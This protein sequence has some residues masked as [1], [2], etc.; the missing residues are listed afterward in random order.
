MSITSLESPRH[1]RWSVYLILIVIA[2]GSMVGRI[3]A[4]KSVDML[5]VERQLRSQNRE[6]WHRTRPFLSANDRSRWLTVRALVEQNTYAIDDV[7]KDPMWDSIDIVRHKGADGKEHFYSSKP[8]LLPTI[9]AG[10]YWLINKITGATLKTHP[11]EI[12]RFMLLTINV[13]AMVLY[14]VMLA[15]LVERIGQTDW[16]RIFTVSAAAFGTL[17]TTFAIVINNHLIAAASAAVALL[18][19]YRI[20]YD[21]ERRWGYF[22]LAGF[23]GAF[24]AANEYPALALFAL[25]TLGLLIESPL[26][27][28]LAYLP[29]AA[30]VIAAALGT[31]YL[32]HGTITSP[33]GH[34]GQAD[35]D[36]NWYEF[37]YERNGKVVESYWNSPKGIDKGEPDPGKYALHALV[38][39][40]GIFSLTPLWLLSVAGIVLYGR[41]RPALTA[42]VAMTSLACLAFYLVQPITDV[43]LANYGGMTSGFRWVFWLAPLWLVAMVPVLDSL[44]AT[45]VRRSI[46]LLLLGLS[47]M[48]ASYPTWNP[49]THP[50]LTDLLMHL[51]KVTF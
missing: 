38:G 8:A 21:G 13:P 7:M 15:K 36:D 32:A 51:E 34:R 28:L 6:D 26:K 43:K 42:L 12:G 17:L 35:P 18:A 29:A 20:W 4:V 41:R 3:L 14:F 40:H 31:E 1:L 46:A 11:F 49:W 27:T 30:V 44:S 23:C 37:S 19:A 25:L 22:A 48:T 16:G 45:R 9:M 47:V 5:S 39:H 10:E 50:W 33:Y 2:A 24:A